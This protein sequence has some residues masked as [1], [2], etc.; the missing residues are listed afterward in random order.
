[1]ANEAQP[2]VTSYYYVQGKRV[3]LAPEPRYAAVRFHRGR[4]AESL[5]L[6]A[7]RLLQEE[8]SNVAYVPQYDLKLFERQA[9]G[10]GEG[11][12][13]RFAEAIGALEEEDGVE[14]ASVAVRRLP[15]SPEVS[16]VT[17]QF[18]VQFK[19]EVTRAAIDRLNQEYGVA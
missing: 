19:P 10:E 7:R 18:L 9:D 6:A 4:S 3:P 15:G 8:S 14:L 16:F 13:R 17:R 1:M 12:A 5:G 2:E 11:T